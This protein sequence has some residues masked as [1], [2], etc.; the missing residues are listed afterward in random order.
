MDLAKVG[1]PPRDYRELIQKLRDPDRWQLLTAIERE[2]LADLAERNKTRPRGRP[3]STDGRLRSRMMAREVVTLTV[4]YGRGGSE[5]A[6]ADVADTFG[7][8]RG[9][10]KEAIRWTRDEMGEEN[11]EH[12]KRRQQ[13]LISEVRA[14]H[15]WVE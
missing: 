9:A 14:E 5:A 10:V 3:K 7:V 15:G 8:D 1:V 4:Y 6:L 13:E 11:W 2:T 12:W